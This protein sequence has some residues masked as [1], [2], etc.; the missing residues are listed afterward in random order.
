MPAVIVFVSNCPTSG[1][2]KSENLD[3]FPYADTFSR[4]SHQDDTSVLV[5]KK[6]FTTDSES[7]SYS[8][9]DDKEIFDC[10]VNLPCLT[11]YKNRKEQKFKKCCRSNDTTQLKIWQKTNPFDIEYQRETR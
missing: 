9:F 3:R 5:G 1:L 7:A 6:S 10:L 4:L 8:L 2:A 11:S